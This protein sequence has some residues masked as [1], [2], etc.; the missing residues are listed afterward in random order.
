MFDKV[1]SLPSGTEISV[2]VA[3]GDLARIREYLEEHHNDE[4]SGFVSDLNHVSEL[5]RLLTW[6][7]FL[8]DLDHVSELLR[9]LAWYDADCPPVN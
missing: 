1:I 6:Y 4:S 2:D 3:L 9:M 7:W 5:L 8:S